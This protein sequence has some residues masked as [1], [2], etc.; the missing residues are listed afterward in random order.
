MQQPENKPAVHCAQTA[1]NNG[2]ASSA[3]KKRA[4]KA[5]PFLIHSR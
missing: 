5:G 2:I 1:D 4:G 3:D